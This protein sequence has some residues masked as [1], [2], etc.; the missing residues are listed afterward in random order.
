MNGNFSRRVIARTIAAKLVAE[1]SRSEHWMKVLAAYL[2]E[3]KQADLAELMT[4]DIAREIF[5]QRGEL[6]VE[7]TSSHEMTDT[8]RKDLQN[9]LAKA[10]GAKDVTISEQIDPDLLGGLVAQTPDAIL[11]ASVRSQLK[12]LAAI[13]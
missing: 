13:N 3:H 4:N 1:P 5:K 9:A 11:D 10:T 12:Q 7:V 2:L 8:I 6:L